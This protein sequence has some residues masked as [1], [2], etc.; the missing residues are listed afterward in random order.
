[1]ARFPIEIC[2]ML[3]LVASSTIYE[4]QGT[5]L[6]RH[7]MRKFPK[8]SQD[9]EP[10]AYK[11]ML[12]FVDNLESMCPLKGEYKDFFSKLKAFI[13]FINTAKGSSSEFQS[14]MKSQSEG[15]FKA[16]SALGVKGG[17]S[18]DTSKLIESL[19]SMGKTFA[20]FKRSGAT[21]M[22]S[23]QRRELVIS[24]S[25]WAQVIGQFVKTVGEKSGDGGNIDLSSILG[26]GGSGGDNGSPSSDTSFPSTDAGTPTNSGS[27]PDSTGD[28]GTSAGGPSGSTTDSGD[29]SMGDT[30]SGSTAG[31][32]SGSTTDSLMGAGGGA[33]AD[34]ENGRTAAGGEN[35]GAAAGD[36]SGGAA[37]DG[38]SREAAAGVES[39]GAAA[40]GENGGAAADDESGG[41]AADGESGEAAAGVE[42]GRAAAGGENGGAAADGESGEAA[43]DGESGGA[44]AD[45]ESGEAAAGGSTQRTESGGA[46]SMGGATQRTESG[47][48]AAVG[49]ESETESSMIG[50]GAYIDS[51]G[52]SPASSPSAGGPSGSTTKNSMEGVAGGSATVTSYQAANYQKTHS[53]SSG[54]SSFSHSLEEKNS[55]GTN[56]DS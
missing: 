25:K 4:A 9:F 15:L 11:G 20:E 33:A 47:G 17:S 2:L 55:G 52:G 13:S 46:N 22:T 30:G 36:E 18:A 53:K 40:G 51:T 39:G 42:S 41:A 56:A 49:G 35:G 10:F 21:T 19:M 16:I 3:I 1:M 32:P 14:Q 24:M 43:A 7:Y 54:K 6:L 8:M 12:S 37:A 5:F 28:S 26:I 38:E 34:G 29:G 44:A 45:G 48:S 27:Y 50:G 31:G 23:E